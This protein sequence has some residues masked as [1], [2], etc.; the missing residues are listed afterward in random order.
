[1]DESFDNLMRRLAA[2]S[3]RRDALR[4]VCGA[5]LGGVAFS[6]CGGLSSPSA[7]CSSGQCLG[8]DNVCYGPCASG[9]FCT[10]SPSGSCSA[11]SAG[12]VYCCG[13]SSSG[14]SSGGSCPCNPGNTWNF[15]TQTCC[16]NSHPYYYPGTHGGQSGCYTTCPYVGDCGSSFERC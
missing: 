3:S 7:S 4:I 5:V 13:G 15:L 2:A 8:T 11:P 6:S 1:M 9:L 14:G 12:G 16:A 10:T